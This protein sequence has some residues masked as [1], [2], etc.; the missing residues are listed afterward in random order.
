MMSHAGRAFFIF[1]IFLTF[2]AQAVVN[3][4]KLDSDIITDQAK[5][6][7]VFIKSLGPQKQE[8]ICTGVL[9]GPRV[10]LTAGHCIGKQVYL[11]SHGQRSLKIQSIHVH[12]L[13]DK[14]DFYAPLSSQHDL[15]VII[16]K[17]EP[18]EPYLIANLPDPQS[19]YAPGLKFTVIGYGRTSLDYLALM[20]GRFGQLHKGFNTSYSFSNKKIYIDQSKEESGICE[21]DSGGP[22]LLEYGGQLLVSGIANTVERPSESPSTEINKIEKINKENSQENKKKNQAKGKKEK[23]ERPNLQEV[24]SKNQKLD[25]CRGRGLYLDLRYHLD[26]I[27][28]IGQL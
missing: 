14:N 28:K 25:Y 22:L 7:V 24:L 5:S 11:R 9:I 15:A 6:S 23:I 27:Y 16:L 19:S 18:A 10:V 20:H 8:N 13:F 21:G 17:E 26:W 1:L 2:Q 12:P 3:G 4:V